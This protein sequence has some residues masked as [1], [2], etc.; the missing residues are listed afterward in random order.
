MKPHNAIL[1]RSHVVVAEKSIS[2]LARD[3][4][5]RAR[6]RRGLWISLCLVAIALVVVVA[7]F[8]FARRQIGEFFAHKL[9]ERL[10]EDGVF[11]RWKSADWVPGVGIRLHGLAVYRDAAKND[12]LALLGL[13]TARRP[14]PSF[15]RWDKM[16]FKTADTQIL[17]GSGAGET[18]L[19]HLDMLLLVQPGKA[20]LPECHASLQGL[21]IEA[22]CAFVALAHAGNAEAI[23]AARQLVQ[24]EGLFHNVNLDWLKS[25][26]EGLN[27]QP[28]K[29]E[30]VLRMD[31]HSLPDDRG[32]EST[33]TFDGANFQWQGQ[34]WDFMQ[35]AVKIPVGKK[36]SS[37]PIEI[38][39][40]RIGHAGR[41]ADIAGAFDPATRIIRISK[42]DSGIDALA[43]ARAMMPGAVARLSAVS[44]S[45]DG[46]VTGAGEIPM[47]QPENFRW[48]GDAA[49]DGELVYA[50]GQTNIALQKPT[51][52][53]R[54]EEQVVTISDL[55]AGLWDGSLDVARLQVPL[56][57]KERKLRFEAQL[58]LDGMRLQSIINIFGDARKQPGVVPLDWTGAWRISGAGEIPM[59]QPENFRWNGDMALDGD[60]IYGSAQTNI[61]LQKPT[62]SMRVEEQ[63]VTISDLKARLWEGSVDVA[64]LQLHLPLKEKKLQIDT[65]LSLDG[66]RLESIINSFSEVRK[67]P[68]VV[69]LNWKGAWRISGTAEIPMD[70]PEN[71]RWHGDAAL[72]GELVYAS[73]Q[74]NIALQKPTFSVRVQEQAVTISDLK[75]GLWDGSLAVARLQVHMPSNE[76][77]LR[78]ETQLTLNGARSSSVRKSFSAGQKQ[79]RVVRLNWNGAWRISAAGE[80][81]MDHPENFRWN[82]EMALGG[83]LFYASGA[84][85]VALR[86]PSFSVREEK[87]VVSVSDFKAG[88]WEG[89]F[90]APKTLVY[91]PS[92]K[93]KGRFETKFAI[94]DAR[95]QSIIN[96][97]GGAQTEPGVVQCDWHGGSEFDLA[98]LAGSGALSIGEA[99]FGRVPVVGP[100]HF[101]FN[102]LAPR[103]HTD[104]PSTMTVNHR[105]A[106]SMLYLKDLKLVSEHAR[107][108][109]DGDIDLAREYAHLTARGGLRK[110]PGLITVLFT[111]LLEF[112]GQG[113]VD[114]VRWSVK[115][116]PGF[117][118]VVNA[119]N[120]TT[121]TAD[122]AEKEADRAVKGLIELPGNVLED[123]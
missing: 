86:Q 93:N 10:A 76:K 106:G 33:M 8:F 97:F 80:I 6:R 44:T 101:V 18:K 123:K 62:F 42:F 21:R 94:K 58:K 83:D 112:K 24:R 68:A 88:L 32:M 108:Q 37:S 23:A 90:N 15:L 2:S 43:L 111:W 46:R 47:D 69:P 61:A 64:R 20:D 12:R 104:E 63:A 4:P 3:S 103:F 109:A 45:G 122:A 110:L 14:E 100:L 27:F 59:D 75:A 66:S 60:V 65:Q 19:E 22:K 118:P 95:L 56:P 49:L 52:S 16:N 89:S 74:R 36:N 105:M 114:A 57:S 107:V 82:G 120:K 99:D 51:F 53:V 121:R 7:G 9:G 72:D 77:K 81:P 34:R 29:D 13:V 71:F 25:V 78:V 38:D 17:L 116:F 73:G 41:K 117:H 40:V 91:L 92:A 84:T 39:H 28:E 50:R 26:K 31:L 119:P 70:Q 85:K 96:S 48:N 87:Q 30:P 102:V 35:A 1:A 79:P 67:Q 115:G 98:S 55:K 54:V 113:P 11:V 5:P